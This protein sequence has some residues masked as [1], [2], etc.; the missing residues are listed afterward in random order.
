MDLWQTLFSNED[1][2]QLYFLNKPG[3][4]LEVVK[5]KFVYRLDV[6]E[7]IQ[8]A[9]AIS[10]PYR[11]ALPHCAV[12][13]L[14]LLHDRVP[15]SVLELGGGGQAMQRYF[16]AAHPQVDFVSVEHDLDIVEAN[17]H[18]PEFNSLII[19]HADAFTYIEQCV[20]LGKRFSWLMVD[21]F[22]GKETPLPALKVAFFNQLNQ[23]VEP[24]GWLI[25]N[26][27]SDQ[28]KDIQQLY[29]LISACTF[30]QI[31]VFAVPGQKNHIFLAQKNST[32]DQPACY[33]GDDIE[34]HNLFPPIPP[35]ET[36]PA[37]R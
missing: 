2:K 28:T 18:L 31:K 33:F 4:K 7:V 13:L 37:H 34:Q 17:R 30:E 15:E 21:L 16:R 22:H 26:C 29:D 19:E 1:T 24:S 14:P 36:S 32:S 8:S 20:D 3:T 5:N 35:N 6:N 10:A 27:L 12:M 23:V 9:F 25:I 11:P